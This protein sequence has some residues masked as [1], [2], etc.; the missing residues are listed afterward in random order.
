MHALENFWSASASADQ[1]S[2]SEYVKETPRPVIRSEARNLSVFLVCERREIPRFARNDRGC[3]SRGFSVP[4]FW[5]TPGRI[6]LRGRKWFSL[7]SRRLPRAG[8][9][10]D[11]CCRI[12]SLLRTHASFRRLRL[13][14]STAPPEWADSWTLPR[15]GRSPRRRLPYS[16]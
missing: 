11:I 9:L 6:S 10:G 7:F 5:G 1:I 12:E 8:R 3:V 16:N 15:S 2:E 4:L 13:E 14:V